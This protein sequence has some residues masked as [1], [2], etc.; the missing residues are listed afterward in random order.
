MT[1]RSST[2]FSVRPRGARLLA[3]ETFA[4]AQTLDTTQIPVIDISSAID[5]SDIDSVAARIHDAATKTGF[6]YISNHGID[7][8]LMDQA[9]AVA[10]GFFSLS[11]QDKSTIAVN[12]D[13]RGW[14]ATGMSRLQ[15]SK[16]HD[17]KEVFFWGT[18][19]TPDDPDL[20]AGKPLVAVN[21]WPDGVFPCLK[22]DLLPYYGAVCK[23]G[24]KVL[25]AIA[26]SLDVAPDF[27]KSRYVSPLARGQ[28]V[29]YPPSSPKDE[30][31]ERFGVAPHTDFGVLTLLLQ[32][33]S[34]GLQVRTSEGVWIE[35]PPIPGTLVC[36]IGDLLQRWS[37]DCF[38]S[39]V[40]R[41]INRTQ[42]ARYSIPVFYDPN[43][44]T[45]VD[46]HD[47]GVP[48]EECKYEPVLVGEHIAGRNRRSFAQFKGTK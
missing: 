7:P 31:V 33:Q 44:S 30:A 21:R 25:S 9:F 1:Q 18:E 43:T 35:A 24:E 27:F 41:V 20:L 13:Q 11:A 34:G 23:V 28:M 48:A 19:I 3:M 4:N 46:P 37:N 40:H 5:G 12:T 45:C 16:A 36:N 14:M 47:L 2:N 39:T 29:Y 26:V 42:N 17:L 10:K 8:R 38:A 22:A 6:F 32:D 15:G